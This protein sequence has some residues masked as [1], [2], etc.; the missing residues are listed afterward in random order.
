MGAGGM[1]GALI[2][3][4]DHGAH[5]RATLRAMDAGEPVFL[6][7]PRW[8]TAML[9]E[10]LRQVPA[11]CRAEGAEARP[12]G[13]GPCDWPGGWRGRVM[14]P[15]GG[16]GGRVRF[17]IH[18]RSSLRGAAL[19]L[20]AALEARGMSPRIHGASLTPPWHVSGLMPA[21]RARETGGIHVT[22]DGRFAPDEP[23]P[24]VGLPADGTRVASLVP[25]QLDRLLA[26]PDG[27]SWLR[28]FDL[29]LLGGSAVPRPL[30]AA[31]RGRRL[32]VALT[33]GMTE[34]AAAAALAW[35][36]DLD[37]GE[38]PAGRP[39]PG[40]SFS[41]REGRILVSAPGLCRGH[42]PASPPTAP[43]DTGDLG[44]VMS[45]GRV[46]VT[47]RA[48]RVIATGGEKVDP[49][50]V[51]AALVASGLAKAAHVLGLPD[52]RWGCLVAAVVVARPE[53]EGRLRQAMEAALEPAA[54]PRRYLFVEELPF[55]T[56]GKPD[57][58]EL[59]KL[60]G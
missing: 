50:R 37:E 18:D 26:R 14:V 25:A 35:P 23:L 7:N 10:A 3:H 17:A 58:G 2:L 60:L 54:R 6:G 44:E 4:A 12:R 15:T 21:I 45:D 31:I 36:E 47:G 46:R 56:R 52:E 33:Y 51:E 8:P 30:L 55:D 41:A 20:A 24:E 59:G 1:S 42:W 11:S 40:V 29:I 22:L 28:R 53:A 48:D 38:S 39:L 9:E 43:F 32:P 34:T 49:A 13:V 16:T 57:P 27:A 5:L 19:S